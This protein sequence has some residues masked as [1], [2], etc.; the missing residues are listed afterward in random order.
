MVTDKETVRAMLDRQLAN[1]IF[2]LKNNLTA[3]LPMLA[4][5]IRGFEGKA[6]DWINAKVD[7]LMDLSF[8]TGTET[9]QQGIE[10]MNEI[11]NA[12]VVKKLE[13]NGLNS[14]FLNMDLTK[15]LK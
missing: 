15:F 12:M 5:M 1:V 13:E 3:S 9:A 11:I 7:T 14:N 10:N 2:P 8:P 4:P 6:I